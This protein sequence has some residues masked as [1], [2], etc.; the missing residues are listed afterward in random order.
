MKAM[1]KGLTS[2]WPLL[3]SNNFQ[4]VVIQIKTQANRI[5][6]GGQ[7]ADLCIPFHLRHLLEVRVYNL[8]SGI[9]SIQFA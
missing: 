3:A 7:L 4:I 6:I 1:D 2:A 8:L 9:Q 5:I